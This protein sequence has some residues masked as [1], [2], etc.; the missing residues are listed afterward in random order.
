MATQYGQTAGTPSASG[1]LAGKLAGFP[2]G[3]RTKWF[4]LV[5]WIVVVAAVSPLAA[6]LGDVEKNDAAAWLPGNAE[7]LAV[8]NLQKQFANGETSPAVVVYHRDGGLTDVDRAKIEADRQALAERFPQTP[9]GPA[10][11]SQDGQAVLYAIPF[12][13]TGSN[14]DNNDLS[15]DVKAVRA[16]IGDGGDGLQVKVTGPA[17]YTTDLIDVFGGIDTTLLAASAAVVAVLL[18]LTYRSPF[19]WLV[20]LLSVALANQVATAAVYGLAKSVGLTVNGQSGGILPVLVFGAGT[21]YALLL[22]ARYRE[23]LRRHED[24]HEAMA[25]A[26]R[27]AGPAMLASGGTVILGLLTL[28]VAELNSNQSLGPVGAVG[29]AAALLV[30]LTLLPAVLVIFGRRLFWPFVPRFGSVSHEGNGIWAKIGNRVARRPR[31]VWIGTAIVLAVLALGL[32]GLD[33]NLPQAEQFRNEPDAIA[34][35]K[36]LAASYPAGAGQPATVIA[37]KSAADAVKAVIA[38]TPGVVAVQ[39]DGGA[40]DLVSFAVTLDAAPSSQAAFDTI[41]R[42]RDR[43]HAVAGAD[44]VVGGPDAI[45]LDVARANTRDRRVIIPLVLVVVLVILALLLRALVAPL[46]LIAT[47]VHSF[48]AALGAS[49]VVFDRVFG[50]AAVEGSIPL[51]GFVFLVALGVDYNIFLMSR[52]HEEAKHLGT[53]QGMLKGLAVTGGVITSAGLVL[54]AT[55]GVLSVLPLVS[56]T[57]LGFMVAFGVLLDTLIVRSIL[58]PALTLDLDRRVWWPSRLSRQ[59]VAPAAAPMT[60]RGGTIAAERR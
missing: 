60:V 38:G 42:L 49:I 50:F 23:E 40:G 3:K 30:M 37:N 47:V 43:V 29:I 59:P 34:G 46:L 44:A 11:P 45:N 18:L 25:F 10:V 54:A 4:I 35:Q 55:F 12:I 56:M 28:L 1:G 36:L 26:L 8:A 6:K 14:I 39:I 21:D 16:L 19:V 20:P 31:P 41:D 27:Q 48:A 53:R 33:T 22:I 52:V 7:S 13:D 17:G 32:T 51:L 15:K 58:V 9:P 24:K 57:E 2:A 5:A